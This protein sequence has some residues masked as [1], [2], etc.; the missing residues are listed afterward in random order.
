MVTGTQTIHMGTNVHIYLRGS[1]N[2]QTIRVGIPLVTR[3]GLQLSWH[4]TLHNFTTV[5][6]A[7]LYNYLR[8]TTLQLF[9]SHNYT[10]IC[11][12]QLYNICV[13]QLYNIC[14]AQLYICVA[15]LYKYLR[16]TP[17]QLF[18]FRN[19]LCCTPAQLRPP[20]ALSMFACTASRFLGSPFVRSRTKRREHILNQEG[21]PMLV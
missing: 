9:A 8:R 6:A 11:V 17:V 19:Y 3:R 12:A 21:C 20:E 16:R 10:I 15:Q 18:A 14:V 4:V 5:Y 2:T 13:A 7:Q 1:T